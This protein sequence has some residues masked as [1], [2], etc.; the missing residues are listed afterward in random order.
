MGRPART[1]TGAT[2]LA[3]AAAVATALAV[4]DA[5]AVAAASADARAVAAA[6][7]LTLFQA[8]ATIRPSLNP[9]K[10]VGFAVNITT[11]GQYG[12]K[13]MFEL[14]LRYGDGAVPL[15]EVARQQNL[16]D[17][18]LEQLMGP[19]RKA[20]LVRSVRGAQGGY[21]LA[22]DPAE[23]TIGDVLRVLEGP[24]TPVDCAAD[25]PEAYAYCADGEA[26]TVR[27]VWVKIRDA[28]NEVVDSITLADLR[29][30]ELA[31]QSRRRLVYYI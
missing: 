18:Y 23:I 2:A 14:A 11:R 24:I 29:E 9:S 5:R 17:N 19:L 22:R 28:V 7:R 20:G 16:P 3:G 21:M 4:A 12:V 13:A 6:P 31:K 8:R 26:C 27:G 30:Q 1:P 10:E 25:D 15:R